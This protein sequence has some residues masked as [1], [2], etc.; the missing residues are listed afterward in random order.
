MDIIFLGFL[1]LYQILFS[2]QVKRR[3]IIS[4]GYIRVAS[5]VASQTKQSSQAFPFVL[6]YTYF[7]EKKCRNV[8][9]YT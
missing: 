5:R 2:Q 4:H 3:V 1:I 8:L 6:L 7:L 9:H